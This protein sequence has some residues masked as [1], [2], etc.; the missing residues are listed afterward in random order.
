MKTQTGLLAGEMLAL[1]YA[2]LQ[3]L[4]FTVPL[5]A[6][7]AQNC[8]VNPGV[9]TKCTQVGDAEAVSVSTPMAAYPTLQPVVYWHDDE[10]KIDMLPQPTPDG[11]V[12]MKITSRSGD[13]KI[14]SFPSI[15]AQVNSITR[16]P[17]DKA[18]ILAEANGT[19]EAFLIADLKEGKLIDRIGMYDPSIS[20]DRRFILYVNGY[21]AHGLGAAIQ[22]HLYDTF[23]T[24]RENICGYRQNDPEHKDLDED[25]RGI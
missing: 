20:P 13:S 24:P 12:R 16:N 17:E 25:Y 9:Y 11:E 14:V 7:T 5:S 1:G 23:K 8:P 15:F 2:T 19:A 18:I 3:V 4:I 10:W 6:Q 22:Y 21:P